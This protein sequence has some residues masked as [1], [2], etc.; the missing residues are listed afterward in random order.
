M[1]ILSFGAGM[2]STAMALMSCERAMGKSDL[3]PEVPI[4]DA[5]VFCNLGLEPAW[6]TKQV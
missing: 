1:K 5:V 3:Y 4:H 6:V 2:Q